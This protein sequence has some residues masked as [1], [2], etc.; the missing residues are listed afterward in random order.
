M[1]WGLVG[2]NVSSTHSCFTCIQVQWKHHHFP[3]SCHPSSNL[4]LNIKA[5]SSIH[6]LSHKLKIFRYSLIVITLLHIVLEVE[7]QIQKFIRVCC[8]HKEDCCNKWCC[9][10]NF[11]LMMELQVARQIALQGSNLKLQYKNNVVH[12]DLT[13]ILLVFIKLCE[14]QA[15][16][17]FLQIVNILLSFKFKV[18]FVFSKGS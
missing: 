18:K 2:C 14:S 16:C 9:L 17:T 12:G 13:K 5:L 4:S 8:M 11:N 10:V 7:L 15:C 1:W 6:H 3:L